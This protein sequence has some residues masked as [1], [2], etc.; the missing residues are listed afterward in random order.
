MIVGLGI[1]LVT[2][3]RVERE[4]ARDEWLQGDGI[5][6]S[7]E[8][9]RCSLN[10]S[11][12]LCYAA[13]FAAKEATLKALGVEVAD[14]GMM[15]EVEVELGD[16]CAIVLHDRMKSESEQLGVRRI[17]LSIAPSKRQTGAM[18]ILES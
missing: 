7:Q 2:N 5:F 8:I 6:T 11:P 16:R 18:V 14:L 12:A 13:C 10:R 1:D 15:R 17:R 3:S 9:S 4:L